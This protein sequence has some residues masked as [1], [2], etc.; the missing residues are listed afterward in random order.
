MLAQCT[1][2]GLF[3]LLSDALSTA[4]YSVFIEFFL[5]GGTDSHLLLVDLKPQKTTGSKVEW[6]LE[7]INITANKNTCPGDKSALSPT[8]LRLGSPALTS[9]GLLE[10]DFKKVANYIHRGRCLCH[11]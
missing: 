9:R 5:A 3:V 10:E 7:Q 1:V 4:H 6:V 11:R 8:G 2:R